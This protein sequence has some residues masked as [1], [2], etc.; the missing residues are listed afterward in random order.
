MMETAW[1]VSVVCVAVATP[2]N[3]AQPRLPAR[4]AADVGNQ[5]ILLPGSECLIFMYSTSLI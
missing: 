5:T 1:S 3:F 2:G 4:I